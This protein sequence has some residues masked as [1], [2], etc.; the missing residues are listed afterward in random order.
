MFLIWRLPGLTLKLQKC[1]SFLNIVSN[2][3]SQVL[4][5]PWIKAGSS[6]NLNYLIQTPLYWCAEA[7]LQKVYLCPT[8][9]GTDSKCIIKTAL[10]ESAHFSNDSRNLPRATQINLSVPNTMNK[11]AIVMLWNVSISLC[12]NHLYNQWIKHLKLE[13]DFS[14]NNRKHQQTRPSQEPRND[15]LTKT[16]STVTFVGG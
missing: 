9:Y 8:T 11:W 4:K 15:Q 3:K 6:V 14:T 5:K 1:K 13:C 10:S 7:K 2:Y 16:S 12:L